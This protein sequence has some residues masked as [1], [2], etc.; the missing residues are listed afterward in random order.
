MAVKTSAHG[1]PR[2]HGD[3]VR[4]AFLASARRLFAEKGFDGVSV[5]ELAESA[6]GN[7]ALV[8]YY[9]KNKKGLYRECVM[10]LADAGLATMER[11]LRAPTSRQDFLT[12]FELFVEDLIVS[13]LQLQ[14]LCIILKRDSNTDVVKQLY[15]EHFVSLS[16]RLRVFFRKAKRAKIVRQ[17][18]DT[19]IAALFVLSSAFQLITS[20]RI[21]ADVGQPCLLD[22]QSIASTIRQV[23]ACLLYGVAAGQKEG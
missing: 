13:H 5:K 23:T 10:P 17:D 2:E 14:D 4:D 7:A 8:N 11:T 21:R 9:F 3:S 12:R 6:G 22:K 1:A 18:L 16:N 19:E 15:K 20:D